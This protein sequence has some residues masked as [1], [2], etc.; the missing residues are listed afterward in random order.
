MTEHVGSQMSRRQFLM[1]V[2]KAGGAVAVYSAMSTLGLLGQSSAG[3]ATLPPPAEVNAASRNGKKIVILGAGLAGMAAA[4]EMSKSG[5]Q[6][7][8]LEARARPGG[9]NWTIRRGDAVTEV[10]GVK[11]VARFDEGLYFNPG[12]ARIP[13]HHITMDYCRELGVPLEVFGNVNE[14]SYYYSENV[15]P[16]SGKKVTKR[17]AKADMRGYTSELLAKAVSQNALNLPLSQSDKE[18]LV[19]Y[20]RRE[21]D[22]NADL[23]YKGSGRRGYKVLPGGGETPGVQE[24]PYNLSAI[25]QSGFG[26][27][28]SS[29]YSIDQQMMMF[30]PVGGMDQIGKAF[31]R[32]V[33]H[34]IQYQA[35][36]Q[37][38][39]QGESGVAVTYRAADGSVQ[40]ATGDY[41]ICTIPL[42]VLKDIP[43][44][45][46]KEMSEAIG[47]ISYA[48]TGKIGFQFRR[49]FWEIDE[50]IYS[51]M[52]TTNMDINQIWYPSHDYLSRK[53]VV[54]GYYN[55]G[56]AAVQLGDMSLAAR[57]EY[58]LKQGAKIHPQYH[59][60]F[61]TSFSIAW[62]KT[63]YNMGGWASYSSADRKDYYPTLN[64]PDGRIYLAG[65][66]MSYLTGWM[67]GAFESARLTV[68][69][70]QE[71]V[72]KA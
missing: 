42:S 31:A 46:S 57:E 65:E 15:G 7:V 11:Q 41:C 39:R 40:E 58:A 67:A 70:I 55:F 6:C 13:Q 60:E 23:F 51:G 49:R 29:E 20:L 33:G 47:K 37:R 19:A 52:T 71:R 25:I 59:R 72:M 4:Y 5:Y 35:V 45:F 27:S 69:A 44:D 21:G 1:Q 34:L 62:Q 8:I 17:A 10:G 50:G 9:R 2:G 32:K 3:A 14:A 61:E 48:T 16:L 53:G 12:P 63:A 24:D 43:G 64:K 18:K 26:N 22:L 28:F 66:H 30:Q 54:V 68:K 56:E 38:I 36:V